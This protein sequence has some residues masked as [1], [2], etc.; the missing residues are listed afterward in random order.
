[1]TAQGITPK[2]RPSWEQD[3]RRRLLITDVFAIVVSVFGTQL[4]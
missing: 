3:Y 4:F 2:R 1:M